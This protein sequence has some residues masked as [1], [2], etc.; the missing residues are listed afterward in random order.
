MDKPTSFYIDYFKAGL[1]ERP[2]LPLSSSET[3]SWPL[4]FR[5][6]SF[7]PWF[8]LSGLNFASLSGAKQ[9]WASLPARL[10]MFDRF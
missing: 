3:D 2:F 8:A 7:E 10:R 9:F 1:L 6:P 4:L 5:F